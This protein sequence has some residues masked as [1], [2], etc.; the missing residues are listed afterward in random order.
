MKRMD[1]NSDGKKGAEC[2]GELMETKCET[3][4][5]MN[6]ELLVKVNR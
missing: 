3:E 1:K 2:I 4:V 5:Q 6:G